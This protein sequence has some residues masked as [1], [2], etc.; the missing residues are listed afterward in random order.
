MC[1]CVCVCVCVGEK[2]KEKDPAT[3]SLPRRFP[4]PRSELPHEKNVATCTSR[5]GA[6]R[7]ARRAKAV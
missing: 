2:M 4:A 6:H 3:V 5:R 7:T 1:V